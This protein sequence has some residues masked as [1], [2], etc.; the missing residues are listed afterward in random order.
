MSQGD[1]AFTNVRVIRESRV[2]LDDV[3]LRL[4]D[5]RIAVIGEN[6]SG[7]STLARLLNG[8]VAP[9]SGTVSVHGRDPVREGAKVRAETGFIFPNPAAQI[10]MPTVR[11][12]IAFSF[13][14]QGI[15][16]AK[17][18]TLVSETLETIGLEHLADAPAH[19]LSSG[20]QQLLA[21]ATV[22]AAAPKL[23]IADEPTAMLDL[24]NRERI[25]R[26]LLDTE[27]GHQL[28]L[29]THDLD[30][31][32]ECDTAVWMHEGNV[33]RVGPPADII[34]EYRCSVA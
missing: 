12:D 25:A 1:I 28:V 27:P 2:A 19:S 21:V 23:I 22:L 11:E 30:L 5:A 24:R 14:G 34:A 16:R 7:K 8:L 18:S 6:G 29:V 13:R 32:A 9:T 33:A 4:S 31:A 3:T 20:Q 15:P 26:L 10:I 17:I